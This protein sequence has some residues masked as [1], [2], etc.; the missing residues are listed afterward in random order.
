MRGRAAVHHR[1]D[2]RRPAR[3]AAGEGVVARE[4]WRPARVRICMKRLSKP[5]LVIPFFAT[6]HRSRLPFLPASF[7]SAHTLTL[8]RTRALFHASV[9]ERVWAIQDSKSVL[10]SSLCASRFSSTLRGGLLHPGSLL[11]FSPTYTCWELLRA[12]LGPPLTASYCSWYVSLLR[13]RLYIALRY[14]PRYLLDSS[15]RP[16]ADAF[17]TRIANCARGHLCRQE[18]RKLRRAMRE[19]TLA[20]GGD[21]VDA[22]AVSGVVAG[23][24]GDGAVAE[25]DGDGVVAEGDGDGIVDEGDGTQGPGQH[26][27]DVADVAD[28]AAGADAGGEESATQPTEAEAVAEATAEATEASADGEARA[29]A[30]ALQEQSAFIITRQARW[31]VSSRKADS[32]ND[33]TPARR[34]VEVHELSAETTGEVRAREGDESELGAGCKTSEVS[35][36][37]EVLDK[38]EPE[39]QEAEVLTAAVLQ[40]PQPSA[41]MSV[42]SALAAE[43]E[44]RAKES[45]ARSIE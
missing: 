24:G 38:P 21:G 6:S 28:G 20:V 42:A 2:H 41:A 11:L 43:A 12:M 17:A 25:G 9:F 35:A 3:S 36:P 16:F 40:Q 34:L 10:E 32:V 8:L 37:A 5:R 30:A 1:S 23:D 7:T 19:A 22:E 45:Y 18:V 27:G 4:S 33:E 13:H 15:W 31:Y 39:S 14:V 29:E 44:A 26:D